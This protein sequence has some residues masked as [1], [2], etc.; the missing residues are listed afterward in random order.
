MADISDVDAAIVN[1]INSIVYPNGKTSPSVVL[2]DLGTP[3]TVRIYEGWPEPDSLDADLA[4]NLKSNPPALST[5]MHISV[6]PRP[7]SEK[8]TTRWPPVYVTTAVETPTVTAAVTG[9]GQVTIGGAGAAGIT[10]WVTVIVGWRGALSVPVAATD[11]ATL[12]AA[13]LATGLT[14]AGFPATSVGAVLTITAG[15]IVN[16]L[17]GFTNTEVAAWSQQQGQVQISI[18]AP[19]PVSRTNAALLLKPVFDQTTFLTMPDTTASRFRYHTTWM[20]DASEKV[21]I[22]RRDLVYDVEYNGTVTDIGYLITA[23]NDN[24][25]GGPNVVN[26]GNPLFSYWGPEATP[27]TPAFAYPG[28]QFTSIS[29]G[30]PSPAAAPGPIGP[31]T[32]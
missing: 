6:F 3:M 26:G 4:P 10:Q 29:P 11:T 31:Q 22:Y 2:G 25:Y 19:S 1:L 12:V 5:T 21:Q 28:S 9:Q 30:T 27:I 32:P 13:N 17:V 24:I 8:N 16:A 14:A 23:V 20:L 7:G 15:S 18:W